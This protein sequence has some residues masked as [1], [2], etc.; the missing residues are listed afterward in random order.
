MF[1]F[2]VDWPTQSKLMED[3]DLKSLVDMFYSSEAQDLHLYN[4]IVD[5]CRAAEDEKSNQH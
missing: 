2:S 1:V 5:I 4:L 3:E